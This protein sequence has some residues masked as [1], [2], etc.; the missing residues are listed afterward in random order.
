MK[1][2]NTAV[3]TI[4]IVINGNL[5]LAFT[6]NT[7]TNK[8]VRSYSRQSK[9]H[10][11]I[12]TPCF[13]SI[14]DVTNEASPPSVDAANESIQS[15]NKSISPGSDENKKFKCDSSVEFWREFQ[16]DK[17]ADASSNVR[18]I[19]GVVTKNATGDG[20]S[21]W[22][23]HALRTGYFTGNAVLGVLGHQLHDAL[24]KRG[25]VKN[26]QDSSSALS[27]IGS[28]NIDKATRLQLEA[29]LCYADD[30]KAVQ[31]GEITFPWDAAVANSGDNGN[32]GF[33]F[34][35]H[36]QTNPIYAA[37]QTIKVISE[38]IGIFSR[39]D[40]GKKPSVWLSDESAKALNYPKYYLNDFHYQTD[41]WLSSKSAGVYEAST[42]TLFLGR[43]DA[44]QRRTIL[45]LSRK[46]DEPRDI[47]EI[48]CGTGRFSTFVRDKFPEAKVTL[49]DLSPFYLEVAR[50]NDTYWRNHRGKAALEA[51]GSDMEEPLPATLVQANAEKLPFDNESFDAV[52]CVYLFHELPTEA[53]T[54][55]AAE[56]ARVLKPGGVISFTDSS[57]IGDRPALDNE[58]GKFGN[59]NEPYYNGYIRSDLSTLFENSGLECNEKFV[60]SVSKTISFTKPMP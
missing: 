58:I 48:A 4:A 12:F 52:T 10:R 38:T 42:E 23:S 34:Q 35:N 16:R 15:Q 44:M 26:A 51:V 5:A 2:P 7:T 46:D 11:E 3:A 20:A 8:T 31:A 57:Q 41:G 39:R 50:E 18:E 54:N 60:T 6:V 25:E 37:S 24:I 9:W 28:L 56:M 47:L 45:P 17:F 21:Y 13:S 33:A 14:A 55:A 19:V 29:F 30:W 32:I 43:Q 40:S 27:I 22:A 1:V 53:R 36:R 59:L 49:V